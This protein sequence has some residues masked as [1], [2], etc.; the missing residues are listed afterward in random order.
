MINCGS[1]NDVYCLAM[2]HN[3]EDQPW[4]ATA[5]GTGDFIIVLNIKSTSRS[6][7][8]AV[9]PPARSA[10]AKANEDLPPPY[11]PVQVNA[12][13]VLSL[14]CRATVCSAVRGLACRM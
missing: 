10:K 12:R 6:L 11:G 14:M 9:L 3:G 8:G 5:K 2:P 7:A 13:C 4:L 1:K